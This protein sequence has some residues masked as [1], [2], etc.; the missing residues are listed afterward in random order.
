MLRFFLYIPFLRAH[1][2]LTDRLYLKGVC[3]LPFG[4]R[5][6]NIMYLRLFVCLYL[7]TLFFIFIRIFI[8]DMYPTSH[9]GQTISTLNQ[10]YDINLY[11]GF[12]C[13]FH[14]F[15]LTE[16]SMKVARWLSWLVCYQTL[17]LSSTGEPVK[18]M[19]YL[20]LLRFICNLPKWSP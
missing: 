15:Y 9:A 18:L 12:I 14:F 7:C 2:W 10:I 17:I 1:V 5:F 6:V 20:Q 13:L 19:R 3:L 11:L 16:Y 4:G 8:F